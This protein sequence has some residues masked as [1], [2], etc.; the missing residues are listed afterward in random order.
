LK[1]SILKQPFNIP[2]RIM[3]QLEKLYWICLQDPNNN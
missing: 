1:H 3:Q 2:S